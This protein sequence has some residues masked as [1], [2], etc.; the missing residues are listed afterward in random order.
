MA[1]DEQTK[2]FVKHVRAGSDILR[3]I[4]L[5]GF[6]R[7]ESATRAA[8]MRRFRAA[9][10][11]LAAAVKDDASSLPEWLDGPGYLYAFSF[12][13]LERASIALEREG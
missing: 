12:R 1:R 3:R 13:Q 4:N 5:V 8:V 11:I 7:N 2:E 6:G 10:E 9:D